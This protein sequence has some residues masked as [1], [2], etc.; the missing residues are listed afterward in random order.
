MVPAS[1]ECDVRGY[2]R[3]QAPLLYLGPR[4]NLADCIGFITPVANHR[5]PMTQLI[6][7][8]RSSSSSPFHGAKR[9]KT[10]E[11]PYEKEY[12]YANSPFVR[13]TTASSAVHT[14]S[15][16]M[17][18]DSPLRRAVIRRRRYTAV[19][20]LPHSRRRRASRVR[21]CFRCARTIPPSERK[22]PS[23]LPPWRTSSPS[24]LLAAQPPGAI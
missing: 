7:W 4:K 16:V 17:C 19:E 2:S 21:D 11:T 18:F 12:F 24:T 15:N 5:A 20:V 9:L 1:G 22:S 23:F 6:I 8:S 3:R 10:L 14:N 13:T